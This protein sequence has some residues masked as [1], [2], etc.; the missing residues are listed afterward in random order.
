MTLRDLYN[1]TA[2]ARGHWVI[3]GTPQ[4]IADIFEEWFT[5]ELADGFIIMPAYLPGAFED[6]IKLV[7]PELRRR[8][9]FRRDYAGPT[10]R[11]HFRLKAVRRVSG[12]VKE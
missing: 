10:L 11:D 6:F 9:L 4:R 2:A 12:W 7:V 5:A 3:Y 1:M 8:G